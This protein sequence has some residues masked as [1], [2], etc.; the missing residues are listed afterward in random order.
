MV[1]VC[2]NHGHQRSQSG[3]YDKVQNGDQAEVTK[4]QHDSNIISMSHIQEQQ[5][6]SVSKRE[7]HKDV[8]RI[9]M[10][11]VRLKLEAS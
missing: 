7:L 10:Q 8:E 9:N 2:T 5:P 1:T 11:R 6:F 3:K 4:G